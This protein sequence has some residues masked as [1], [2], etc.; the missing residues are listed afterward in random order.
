MDLRS[1]AEGAERS[2]LYGRFAAPEVVRKQQAEGCQY[3]QLRYRSRKPLGPASLADST[4]VP[5]I[6]VN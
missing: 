5:S 4:C 6:I 1:V 2:H 3:L